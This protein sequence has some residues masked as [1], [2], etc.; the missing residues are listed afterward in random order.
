MLTP[1]GS[2]SQAARLT[3]DLAELAERLRHC[4]VQV[5]GRRGGAG[6][7]IIWQSDGL[8]LTNAHVIRSSR[9]TVDLWNGRRFSA[10]LLGQDSR[11]DLAALRIDATDLPAAT[12]GDSSQLRVGEFVL[13]VGYPFGGSALTTGIIHSTA[14]QDWLQSDV[15]LMPGNSGGL[16]ANARGEVIG[17]NTLIIQGLSVAIPSRA[18]EPFLQQW[19]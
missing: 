7:G 5:H 1:S 2:L 15:L 14:S 18:V 3:Q 8:I 19:L 16:L 6:S 4:T 17:I 10:T 11:R 12:I 9:I 13:A